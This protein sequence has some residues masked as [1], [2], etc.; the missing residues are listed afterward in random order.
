MRRTP[1]FKRTEDKSLMAKNLI[2][3]GEIYNANVQILLD[4]RAVLGRT[5]FQ[6]F[7]KHKQLRNAEITGA[8][9]IVEWML[10]IDQA[11]NIPDATVVK[12]PIAA[13]D[14]PLTFVECYQAL[15]CLFGILDKPHPQ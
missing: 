13:A 15:F 1:W 2:K 14:V 12:N 6:K 10:Q 8:P 11:E 4:V 3:R 9:W 5:T 7:T